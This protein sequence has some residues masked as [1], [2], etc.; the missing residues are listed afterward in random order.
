MGL[1]PNTDETLARLPARGGWPVFLATGAWIGLVPWAPGTFGTLWGVL[2]AWGIGQIELVPLRALVIAALVAVGIPLCTVAARR[3]GGLKD[4]GAIVFD[5]IAAVPIAFF[6]I[7]IEGWTVAGLG[8]L[9][10]RLFD[11]AKPP[12]VKRF[13]KLPEGL[14]IMADDCVAAVYANL[15][16]RLVLWIAAAAGLPLS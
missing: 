12:P 6:L 2:L 9:S 11:I 5:E 4:P 13:E 3:M 16:L 7:P 14:G 1:N 10:F 15:A 8:F